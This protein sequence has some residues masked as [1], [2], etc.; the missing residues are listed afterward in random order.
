MLFR[1]QLPVHSPL[2]FRALLG[3]LAAQLGGGDGAER[4]VLR[5]ISERYR[6]RAVLRTDSG[7][8]ALRLAL[9]AARQAGKG[10]VA[11]PAYVC[12]DVATAADGADVPVLLYDIDLHTLG[13]DW[14][15]LRRVLSAG[16][17]AV[18]VVHLYGVPVDM[19]AVAA[20]A[21]E[22]GAW[23]IED[24]AQGAGVVIRGRPAGAVGSLGVLSFG[25]GKGVTGGGGGALLANDEVGQ[26][27]L[28][29][30]AD[31]LA[32]GGGATRTMVATAAQWALGRP[33][34]YGIP[35]SLP[36][37]GLGET[38]YRP[39]HSPARPAPFTAGVLR[40]TW[41]LA[42][43]EAVARRR[44]A[45]RLIE[46]LR[47]SEAQLE[48][49]SGWAVAEP[50]WLRL[51]VVV[52]GDRARYETPAARRLGIMPGYPRSLADLEGFGERVGNREE[53]FAGARGLARALVTM[54]THG[55]VRQQDLRAVQ[56]RVTAGS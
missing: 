29:S 25:R 31:R 55:A 19:D 38:I 7:T 34:L 46:L 8:S 15:S 17:G 12:Y 21:A 54:A 36:F 3:G 56:T 42:D 2:T 27:A 45:E 39:P 22:H 9:E 32:P 10:P 41:E 23:V 16:A 50:G 11:L 5:L 18:V 35:A 4:A 33:S 28:A 24:A 40:R 14:D 20:L 26:A 49:V 37:L 52:R 47:G 6:S 13:P 1:H 44:N 51:P 43:A 53:G 48:M 30:V